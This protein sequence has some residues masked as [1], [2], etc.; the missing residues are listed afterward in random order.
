MM[1]RG[2]LLLGAALTLA[3]AGNASPGWLS[4]SLLAKAR[5]NDTTPIGVI[6]RFTVAN[7]AQ[8]RELFKNLHLQLQASLAKLGPAAGCRLPIKAMS[9]LVAYSLRH[10][11]RT[12][13][14]S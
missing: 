4:P 14:A 5:A 13:A 10:R 9:A 6:V 12:K 8:G 7:N 3:G 2:I 1:K 11:Q